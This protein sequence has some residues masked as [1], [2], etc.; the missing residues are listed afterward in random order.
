MHCCSM[1]HVQAVGFY[2]HYVSG[3]SILMSMVCC[4]VLWCSH[5]LA[6][7]GILFLGKLFQEV[8]YKS[9]KTRTEKRGWACDIR[10][11]L[12]LDMMLM[13]IVALFLFRFPWFWWLGTCKTSSEALWWVILV[14]N[15]NP[16][17]P[18]LSSFIFSA[19][20]FLCYSSWFIG[21]IFPCCSLFCARWEIQSSGSF[22]VFLVNLCVCFYTTMTW[23]T[24]KGRPN[25]RLAPSFP[26]VVKFG[27]DM[28]LPWFHS[29][30]HRVH[31]A[32][33][34]S[35]FDLTSVQL[36]MLPHVGGDFPFHHEPCIFLHNPIGQFEFEFERTRTGYCHSCRTDI[37]IF[38]QLLTEY[39][40]GFRYKM[41]IVKGFSNLHISSPIDIYVPFFSCTISNAGCRKFSLFI[42]SFFFTLYLDETPIRQQ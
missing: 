8:W 11:R 40:K 36:V 38:S 16:I 13:I 42:L 41:L 17:Q 29:D 7:W 19:T 5:W 32:S 18:C 23:W 4:C 6:H 24:E 39:C 1:P 22:S 37:F 33:F 30:I 25:N 10:L 35:D 26:P 12:S 27:V 28:A 3:K 14:R 34:W 9:H 31:A 21:S 2:W 20:Y 15:K